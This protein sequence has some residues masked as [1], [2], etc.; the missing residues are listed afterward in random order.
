MLNALCSQFLNTSYDISSMRAQDL[1]NLL[2]QKLHVDR[3]VIEKII[4]RNELKVLAE[5]LIHVQSW[6]VCTEHTTKYVAVVL[7][8]L[9]IILL[10]AQ[11]FVF[12]TNCLY[13]IISFLV[14]NRHV[15]DQKLKLIRFFQKKMHIYG[16]IVAIT[17]ILTEALIVWIQTSALLSWIIPQ[18]SIFRSFLFF[19][20]S[21]PV[22]DSLLNGKFGSTESKFSVD[23]GSILTIMLLRW[24]MS[25]LDNQTAAIYVSLKKLKY[26]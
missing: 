19:G 6:D 18:S 21:L 22:G 17:S 10:I 5:S 11:N 23:V 26:S 12:L 16:L 8:A 24:S 20:L 4:D 2:L 13:Y 15:L 25:S 1:R 7:F 3:E 9:A 14:P